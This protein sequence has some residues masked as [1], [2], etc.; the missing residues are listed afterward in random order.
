MHPPDYFFADRIFYHCEIY[1]IILN[2]DSSSLNPN[3]EHFIA[4]DSRQPNY[5]TSHNIQYS[6][7]IKVN[8]A[9]L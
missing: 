6:M 5:W 1:L 9:C 3:P 8:L 7:T 2:I 4:S